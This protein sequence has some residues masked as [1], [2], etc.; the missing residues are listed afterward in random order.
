MKVR[1]SF[2]IIFHRAWMQSIFQ[3][4]FSSGW[5]VN[6]FFF[7]IDGFVLFKHLLF[8]LSIQ[9]K[10]FSPLSWHVYHLACAVGFLLALIASLLSCLEDVVYLLGL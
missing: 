10:L 3:A 5:S 4:E 7:L 1:N 6:E 8:P 9:W 2:K